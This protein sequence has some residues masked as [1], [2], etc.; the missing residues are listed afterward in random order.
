MPVA[1]CFGS[2]VAGLAAE[3]ALLSL[4]WAYAGS[5]VGFASG[6]AGA[7]LCTLRLGSS[8]LHQGGL[9]CRGGSACLRDCV[10]NTATGR[11][12]GCVVQ[13]PHLAAS[14][15]AWLLPCHCLGIIMRCTHNLLPP[16]ALHCTAGML[17]ASTLASCALRGAEGVGRLAAPVVLG[18]LRALALRRRR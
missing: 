18:L 3:A 11:H 7:L 8:L 4:L 10:N 2:L 1:L 17:A 5:L 15:Q 13:A 14:S 16:P 12:P 9:G 6:V